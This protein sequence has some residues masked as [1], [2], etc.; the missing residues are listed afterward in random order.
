M[1]LNPVRAGMVA[2]PQE[3]RWSSFRATAGLRNAPAFLSTDW[4]LLQFGVRR[5]D[6][7]GEYRK[8]VRE[9]LHAP[10]P[11][12]GLVGGFVLGR[13]E[14]VA[15][16]R[17]WL[18]GDEDLREMPQEQRFFDRPPLSELLKDLGPNNREERNSAIAQA[19]L[20]CGYSMK[21]IAD[22]LKLHYMT[23]SRAVRAYESRMQGRGSERC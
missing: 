15:Q 19:Y 14:F 3:W 20:D 11:W 6:A 18:A 2:R 10:S 21:E 5:R 8:F 1:V 23:V 17:A 22:C 13:E 9:G 12:E 7:Q 16:C 4:V